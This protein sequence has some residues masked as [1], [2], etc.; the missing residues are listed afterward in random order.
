MQAIAVDTAGQ[1]DLRSSDRTWIVNEN[2]IAPTVAITTPAV[3]NPPTA[4]LPLT[5]GPGSPLTFT[6]SA[7]DDEGLAN[8]EI[9]LRN[10]VTQENLS[11]GGTWGT[12][13]TAGWYRITAQNL[14]GSSVNWSYTTPF[15]LRPGTYQFS[16][17]A[18][19]DIGLTTASSYQGNLTINVQVPGDAPPNGTI[20]PTGTQPNLQV[21]HLDLA[22]AA[23]D[24]FGVAAVRLT[25]RD[26]DSSRYLQPN[27]TLAAPY[28]LLD[29]TLASLNATSTTWTLSVDLPSQGDYSVTAFAIDTSDQQ[30]LSTSGA[31]ARYPAYPGDQPPVFVDNLFTPVEGTAFTEARIVVSGRLEDDQQIAQAQVAIRNSAG[32]YMNSSGAFTSS[33]QSWR[34]AFLNSPGSPGSNFA[35]TSPPIP[36][37]AYTVFARGV[38]QHGFTTTPPYERNVTVSGPPGNLPPVASFTVSCIENVCSFDGRSSTDENAP[39][40]IYS[41]N[42]GNGTGSGPIPTRTYTSANTYTVT[43]TVRDE[44]GLTGTTSQVITIVEP[45]G[46]VAPTPVINPPSCAGLVCNFSSVGSAD[47]NPGDTFTRLWNWG[48]G[49]PTSTSTSTSHTFA[50]PGTYTVTLTVTD[51]WGRSASTT[52]NVTV[53]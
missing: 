34:T 33:S 22:G 8:V 35:Y 5:M 29:A 26:N 14:S 24:D 39:T 10:T 40:L 3:M 7:T 23:T 6:G 19:D 50:G 4:T 1:P 48:D 17:R 13:V 32:L 16:V 47:P 51:G 30:D 21:L 53:A 25:I 27:G 42:F 44:W 45:A 52:L 38:D 2:A 41:W 15:N 18:N 43:L 20:S 49:T 37:G 36:D 46:N 12:G 31:T 28:A 9:F 11:S